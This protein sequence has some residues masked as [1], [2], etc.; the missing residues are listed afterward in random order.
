MVREQYH[1]IEQGI[2]DIIYTISSDDDSFLRHHGYRPLM[3]E[4]DGNYWC[5][6]SERGNEPSSGE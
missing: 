6:A 1:Y 2:P 3:A 5:R 4:V